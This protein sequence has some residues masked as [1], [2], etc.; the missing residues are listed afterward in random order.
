M[1][2]IFKTDDEK[3]AAAT[4]KLVET[5]DGLLDNHG[6]T[7]VINTVADAKGV[8]TVRIAKVLADRDNGITD[9]VTAL[10][11]ND[12]TN[13]DKVKVVV[14][15]IVDKQYGLADIIDALFIGSDEEVNKVYAELLSRVTPQTLANQIDNEVLF[16]ALAI[17]L[18]GYSNLS[19]EVVARAIKPEL[20]TV[21]REIDGLENH[22]YDLHR[23]ITWYKGEVERKTSAVETATTNVES[24][25]TVADEVKAEV[26]T[27][28]ADF[29]NVPDSFR[30]ASE[31]FLNG[32]R[33]AL[34]AA[35]TH[36]RTETS[37]LTNYREELEEA[38]SELAT[39]QTDV[40]KVIEAIRV[41]TV[42]AEAIRDTAGGFAGENPEWLINA[43]ALLPVVTENSGKE[44][45]AA[46]VAE[47]EAP[48][49]G[50]AVEG[51]TNGSKADEID[52]PDFLK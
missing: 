31:L 48:S 30:T 34:T 29:G 20:D 32:R 27:L 8:S 1:G 52:V 49:E 9:V 16:S 41:Q 28:E 47:I 40:D 14:K 23:G 4:Q 42:K 19:G 46:P 10:V 50:T 39:R 2:R 44:N 13:T 3:A 11:G 6:V 5:V 43:K 33:E 37:V 15:A 12:N 18:G 26:D 36:V 51:T 17:R 21:Q 35:N 22:Y 7:D 45:E 38:Q 25:Q 24:A